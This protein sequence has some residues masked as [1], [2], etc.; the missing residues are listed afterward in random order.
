MPENKENNK[1]DG[2]QPGEDKRRG[3]PKRGGRRGAPKREDREFEQ[4]IIDL[5][6]VT[7]VMA[8]G[9]RMRFRACVA[10]GDMK[11]K[12]G[13]GLAKGADVSLAVN[14]AVA[15]AKKEMITVPMINETIPHEVRI[16]E[17][18]AR[19]LI[20]PAPR[21]TGVKAGGAVRVILELA[22][23]PNVVAKILGTN[24]KVSNVNALM[25]ALQS[26]KAK[27]FVKKIE[28]KKKEEAQKKT[29]ASKEA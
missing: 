3:G 1:T 26:F 8:G 12:V 23:V 4:R 5:A 6:R 25:T 27:K 19:I 7:R 22:G 20:K 10:I 9:K 24:N 15:R 18:A 13:M 11:G 2:G 14:K 16:K 17:K 28:P 29:E 21:G